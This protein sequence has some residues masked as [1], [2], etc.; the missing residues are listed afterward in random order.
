MRQTDQIR[1]MVL[2][3]MFTA[4]ISI[5]AVI[6]IP[7]PFTPVP[8]VINT[9]FVIAAG[10]ILPVPWAAASLGLYLLLGAIGLPVFSGGSGGYAHFLS[11]TGGY[12]L[13]FLLAAVTTSL[14]AG[15]SAALWRLTVAGLVG[16]IAIY[17]PGVIWL[18]FSAGMTWTAAL[19]AGLVPFLIGD[20]IKLAAAVGVALGLKPLLR[21]GSERGS[22]RV[23]RLHNAADAEHPQ[24]AQDA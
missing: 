5:G 17:V 6:A 7:L 2:A 4:L 16:T 15:R 13:G 24:S 10:L 19:S 20:A 21:A 9:L 12:L 23:S 14:I 11:P 3:A 8:I 18:K 22:E 1:D